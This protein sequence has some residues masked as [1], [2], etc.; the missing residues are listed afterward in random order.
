MFPKKSLL[1]LAG[2]VASL[3]VCSHA[4]AGLLSS[5]GSVSSITAGSLGAGSTKVA[6]TG[7]ISYSF[8]SGNTGTVREQ[9]WRDTANPNGSGDL[10]FVYQVTVTG[11]DIQHLN[12]GGYDSFLTDVAQSPTDPNAGA[13]PLGMGTV[14]AASVDRLTASTVEWNFNPVVGVG[15]T[16]YEL[17]VRTNATTF[18]PGFIG[19]IDA[20]SSPT[21][22]GLAPAPPVPEPASVLVFA[23]VLASLGCAAGWRRWRK[24]APVVPYNTRSG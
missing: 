5:G 23:S 11:N 18:G 1:A 15:S 7:P 6:D 22:T 4:R 3:L 12:G 8:G 13:P 9:V 10:S 2:V 20:G 21:I 17:I 14:A 24:P 16:G 19:L